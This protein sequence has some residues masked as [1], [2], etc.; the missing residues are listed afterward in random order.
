MG[1]A[2]STCRNFGVSGPSHWEGTSISAQPEQLTANKRANLVVRRHERVICLGIRCTCCQELSRPPTRES[3]SR[4]VCMDLL[5]SVAYPRSL[6]LNR[7]GKIGN[8]SEGVFSSNGF[9]S[10]SFNQ[11]GR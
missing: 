6:V 4:R 9:V 2:R 3:R 7:S 5:G 1:A 11:A 10:G 8:I